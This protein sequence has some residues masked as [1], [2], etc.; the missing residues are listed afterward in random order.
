MHAQSDFGFSGDPSPA[1]KSGSRRSGSNLFIA[2]RPDASAAASALAVAQDIRAAYRAERQ[3]LTCERLHVSLLNLG[4]EQVLDDSIVYNARQAIDSVRFEPFE[5]VFDAVASFGSDGAFPVVLRPS[6]P[7][8][9]LVRLR[10]RLA[11]AVLG[12][13][14]TIY[15]SVAFEPH[16]TLL[17]HHVPITSE[18]LETPIS[19][20]VD[21]AWLIH[22][23][24][25]Q[26]KYEFLWPLR[27]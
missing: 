11:Y 23:L 20:V 16:M 14:L 4:R 3:P 17:Y 13:G 15:S 21:Q 10:D 7:D 12:L 26:T 6:R 19:M 22:S 5:V 2:L 9:Q 18:R 24:V 8:A 1:R 25:G 27:Q